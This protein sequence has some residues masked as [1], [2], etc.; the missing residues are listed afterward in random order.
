MWIGCRCG[1]G[2]RIL[3]W[4]WWG[5]KYF[6]WLFTTLLQ[7]RTECSS[8]IWQLLQTVLF[9]KLQDNVHI[10]CE[11]VNVREAW[12]WI[13]QRLL[14]LLPQ[15][16]G[17]LSNFEFLNLMFVSSQFENEIVWLLGVYVQQVWS[18]II[19]KK[20]YLSQNV[21]KTE[22]AQQYTIHQAS[23]RPS[24]VLIIDLI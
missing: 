19:C 6:S 12:F 11:C 22:C 14:G 17:Q 9:V 8:L 18:N 7:I 5:E 10:F 16:V 13:R 1:L 24:L 3:C 21:I 20:K 23:N 4:I 15:D 2:C